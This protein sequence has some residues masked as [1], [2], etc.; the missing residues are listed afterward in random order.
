ME[1]DL[2][3]LGVDPSSGGGNLPGQPEPGAI[4]LKTAVLIQEMVRPQ[5][6]GVAFSRNPLT[7]MDEV[8]VE[9]VAGSGETLVQDGV[10]PERWVNKWGDWIARPGQPA[11]PVAVIQEV[12]DQT[13][14]IAKAYGQ[15][16]DLEW[17]YDGATVHWVQVR[18]I[19]ALANV[20]ST[21]IRFP[22]G[23]AW[24]DQ[25]ARVVGQCAVGQ[26]RLGSIIHRTDWPQYHR[27]Q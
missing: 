8:V 13:K 21:P 9:A 22:R 20:G 7:G 19:T 18:P 10:T 3:R 12:V 1:G 2:R 26:Q 5:V 4:A 16:V 6:S 14:R 27:P 24:A 11:L 15:P 23:A 25:T 17:V